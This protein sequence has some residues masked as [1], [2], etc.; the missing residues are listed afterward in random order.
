[1]KIFKSIIQNI[2]QFLK[3]EFTVKKCPKH[4]EVIEMYVGCKSCYREARKEAMRLDREYR[5]EEIK[6]AIIRA[7]REMRLNDSES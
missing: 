4:S 6:E 1:M 5:I 3:D 2:K 7:K